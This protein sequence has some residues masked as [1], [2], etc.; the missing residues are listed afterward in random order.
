MAFQ[1]QNLIKNERYLS[2]LLATNSFYFSTFVADYKS[3]QIIN[4]K[5]LKKWLITKI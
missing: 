4:Y 2:T 1:L 5:T 3:N